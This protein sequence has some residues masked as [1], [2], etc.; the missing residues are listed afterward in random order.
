MKVYLY[1]MAIN[2]ELQNL[3]IMKQNY[4]Q[5]GIETRSFSLKIIYI[6]T[7][8]TEDRK[9]PSVSGVDKTRQLRV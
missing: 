4:L 3:T 9:E 6:K 8:K 1:F 7:I 2:T 5:Y